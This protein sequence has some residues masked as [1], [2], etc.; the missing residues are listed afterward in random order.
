MHIASVHLD[1][2]IPEAES[3]GGG[4]AAVRT[5]TI[6]LQLADLLKQRLGVGRGHIR[7]THTTTK[8]TGAE[9]FGDMNYVI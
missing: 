5:G 1:T 8:H 4:G 6:A 9:G 7:S 2:N 3:R